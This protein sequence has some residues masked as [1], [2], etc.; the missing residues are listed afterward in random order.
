MIREEIKEKIAKA[1]GLPADQVSIEHTSSNIPGDYTTNVALK[2]KKDPKEIAGKLECKLFEKVETAGPGFIN[3]FLS[4]K[5]LSEEVKEILKKKGKYGSFS[6]KEKANIE[7]ISANPTGPLH[8]GHGRNAFAGK[9]IALVLEKAGFKVTKDYYINDAQVSRQI[10]TVMDTASQVKE[11]GQ[12]EGLPYYTP[13]LQDKISRLEDPEKITEQIMKENREFIEKKLEIK[14]DR[15][16]SEEKDLFEKKKVRKIFE[17]LE[18]K[19]LVYKKEEAWWIKTSKFGDQKDWVVKRKDG[20]PTYLLS[21]IAYHKE[22]MDK[23]FGR[24]INILGADHQAHASKIRAAAKILDYKGRLD[25][26]ILQLVTLKGREKLSKRKGQIVSLEELV[27]LIGLDAASFFY[28]QKSLDT[29]MEIDLDLAGEKSSKNPV[30]YVQYAHAR[31]CS[32]LRKTDLKPELKNPE[33]PSELELAKK[34]S[35]FPE[36]VKDTARDYQVQ[37]LPRYSLELASFFHR[38]YR[39][40][41][42]I[43]KDRD[44]T[45]SRLALTLACK[46]VLKQTLGLMGVSSPEKM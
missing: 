44:L 43:S 17:W 8:I 40:C 23:G 45:R 20:S 28:L 3:L 26:L 30:Y 11:S 13:Y 2:L 35:E 9:A 15:W 38:F 10:K 14:F 25:I 12:G 6:Q 4:K 42:V 1:V 36:I 22:K 21:D 16:V 27:D 7:F 29:H 24:I 32:I 39:D 31:I 19:N 33:H 5:A 37:R 41:Q 46:N 18:K 34:L